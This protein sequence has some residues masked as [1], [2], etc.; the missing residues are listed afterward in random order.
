MEG[1]RGKEK[2]VEVQCRSY[3]NDSST[4]AMVETRDDQPDVAGA[5]GGMGATLS[6][7]LPAGRSV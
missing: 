1:N 7:A 4:L 6:T 3:C 2:A 5:E